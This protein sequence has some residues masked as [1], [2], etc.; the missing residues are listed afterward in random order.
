[1]FT[2]SYRLF[3]IFGFRIGI[4]LSWFFL[5]ALIIWSLG[6]GFFPDVLPGLAQ[7]AYYIMAACAALGM[8]ASIVYHELA[9]ALVARYY[10]IKIAGITLFIFGGVAELEDEP[11]TAKSEFLVAIAGPISSYLLAGALYLLTGILP[12]TLPE[13]IFAVLSYLT[14]I[15]L[16]LATFNL[17]PAFPLDG[18]RML[19]AGI[20]WARGSLREATRIAS[21]LGMG[22]GVALIAYGA[23]NSFQGASVGGMWQVLI[24]FFV[25]NA[26]KSAQRNMEVFEGLRGVSVRDLMRSPPAGV[27]AEMPVDQITKHVEL[28]E[29]KAYLPVVADGR[30]IG[31]VQPSV[32]NEMPPERQADTPVG[33]VAV[34]LTDS[35]RLVPELSAIAALHRLQRARGYQAFVERNGATVGWI[36][37]RTIFAYL[38]RQPQ[39]PKAEAPANP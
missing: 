32:L 35:E 29:S 13:P 19:R 33:K 8:F 9:H 22:L 6:T 23:Y 7:S 3:S 12:V 15:N 2:K 10:Q 39:M 30:V 31:L 36:E 25:V 16:V 18:G 26:A 4:D 11:P 34:P 37:A 24:G 38:D 27:P 14:L 21:F 1:M 28:R 5:A 17:I 20:W